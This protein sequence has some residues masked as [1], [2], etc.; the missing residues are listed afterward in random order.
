MDVSILFFSNTKLIGKK[1]TFTY[2]DYSAFELW[3]N[4]MPRLKEIK[5]VVG[6]DL[7]NI[8]INPDNFDFNPNTPFVK[9]A[10]IAVSSFDFIP[11]DME[12]LEISEGLYAVFNYKG[13]QSNAAAFF[14]LIYTE[15]LPKSD[16]ELDNRPHFEILGDKYKNNAPDSEEEIWIP[17]KR[18]V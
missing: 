5:N 9:W 16:F 14:N 13:N 8:Q 3:S 2:A 4:F 6:T 1:L 7:Y 12:I 10:A 15:W 18:K 11:A 17:I